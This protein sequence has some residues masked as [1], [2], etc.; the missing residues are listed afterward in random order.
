[1]AERHG[2]CALAAS[3]KAGMFGLYFLKGIIRMALAIFPLHTEVFLR[4]D[5]GKDIELGS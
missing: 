4:T 5:I 2:Q 1:M 3:R